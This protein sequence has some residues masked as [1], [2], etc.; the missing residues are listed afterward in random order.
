[1]N[2]TLFKAS[3]KSNFKALL[4]FSIIMVFYFSMI[5]VMY[6]PM[7]TDSMAALIEM[8][9]QQLINML[10]FTLQVPTYTGF[11]A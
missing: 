10:G 9:P 11:V 8:L 4:I 3:F 7:T 2:I 5:I 6:D 1:M